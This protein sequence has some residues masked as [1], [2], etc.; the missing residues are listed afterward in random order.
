MTRSRIVRG[1]SYVKHT[2][3]F[4]VGNIDWRK[5][6]AHWQHVKDGTETRDLDMTI[7]AARCPGWA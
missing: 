1:A 2:V 7:S 5:G 3:E 4:K 6:T